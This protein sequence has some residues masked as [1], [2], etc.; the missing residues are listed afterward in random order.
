MYRGERRGRPHSIVQEGVG[1]IEEIYQKIC[2]EDWNCG[3]IHEGDKHRTDQTGD[4]QVDKQLRA[5]PDPTLPGDIEAGRLAQQKYLHRLFGNSGKMQEYNYKFMAYPI[6]NSLTH[7]TAD[8]IE[9][10]IDYSEVMTRGKYQ[11][12]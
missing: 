7:E 6:L 10:L 4:V 8:K 5:T 1:L 2:E 3:P 9:A 11:W 12:G